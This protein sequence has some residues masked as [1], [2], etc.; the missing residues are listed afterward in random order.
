M[1]LI[2]NRQNKIKFSEENQDILKK[3]IDYSLKEEGVNSEY[4]VSVI[5][6]DNETIKKINNENRNID[7]I[8]DVLSFPMLDY[9]QKKVYKD[10]YKDIKFGD[11]YLNEGRIV[12]GDIAISLE[13]AEQQRLEFGHSFIREC[14]YLSVHSVL[15]LLG[16]DHMETEDK[17]I[18][19]NREEEILNK[20]KLNR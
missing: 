20:F 3:I 5:L 14:A 17:K 2:D 4:E 13:R 1:I 16:Y 6:I 10:I 18:M 7:S 9:P 19:R 15:H 11:I 8:T 12:L